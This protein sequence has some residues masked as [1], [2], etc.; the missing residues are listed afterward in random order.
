MKFLKTGQK[1][2]KV[3][4]F[5]NEKMNRKKKNLTYNEKEYLKNILRTRDMFISNYGKSEK[6]PDEILSFRKKIMIDQE[7]NLIQYTK[8]SKNRNQ[9]LQIYN[10]KVD[11]LKKRNITPS[12]K[13]NNKAYLDSN[14]SRTSV[15]TKLISNNLK[16]KFELKK[17]W[18]DDSKNTKNLTQKKYLFWNH[19][20]ILCGHHGWVRCV[21]VDITNDF[22]VTGSAD[23][24]IKIWDMATCDLKLTLTGHTDHV[25]GVK[26]SQRHPYL[27]SVGLD[28]SVKCWD[29]EMN[30]VI[31]S[32]HGHLSGIFCLNVM[33]DLEILLTGGR[34]SVCR[35]WDI[36][37]KKQVMV[38]SGHKNT[39]A[40]IDSQTG[41][42]HVITG[43]H[44]QTIRCWD[45]TI[46]RPF[47][48]LTHHKKSIRSLIF[49]SKE[50]TFCSGSGDNLKVWKCPESRFL[51]NF[52]KRP[53]SMINTL[54]INQDNILVA[55]HQTG[56]VSF[57]DWKTGNCFQDSLSQPQPGSIEAEAG[58]EECCFDQSGK[59]LI[60]V[61]T[62]KTI[63]IW[64]EKGLE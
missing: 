18:L 9:E 63:K 4:F 23:R 14:A 57:W 44:D 35:V 56:H 32:Y 30:K 21:D 12:Y 25:R 36:R 26:L 64:R 33:K 60:T 34:D 46:G 28:Q 20:K 42:P 27:F 7:F 37:T 50:Y 29:L 47:V 17:K 8:L 61:E 22:F 24:T 52:N 3:N 11:D 39:V 5:L 31:R 59:Q 41:E 62:D 48:V 40:C 19:S 53:H 58:I 10:S 43:S 38:L 54:A 49:H 1:N 6:I 16:K 51:R 45:I 2:N 15:E 13:N 55:G